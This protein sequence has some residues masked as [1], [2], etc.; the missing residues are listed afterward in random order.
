[1][2]STLYND[3]KAELAREE[4]K[5][6]VQQIRSKCEDPY[7]PSVLVDFSDIAIRVS[8]S[9]SSYLRELCRLA[10]VLWQQFSPLTQQ[11]KAEIGAYFVPEVSQSW[12]IS[13]RPTL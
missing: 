11:Q 1:M 12:T 7:V 6:L 8:S 10:I 5:Q 13:V 2:A 4:R 3:H 9:V